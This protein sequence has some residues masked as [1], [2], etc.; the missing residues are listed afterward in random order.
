MTHII[1]TRYD[2]PSRGFW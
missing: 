2:K 1:D